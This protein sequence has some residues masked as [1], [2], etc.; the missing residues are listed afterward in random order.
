MLHCFCDED[1]CAVDLILVSVAAKG[2]MDGRFGSFFVDACGNEMARKMRGVLAADGGE[3][4]FAMESIKKGL[5]M[6]AG[7]SDDRDI[8]EPI[9]G[10]EDACIWNSGCDLRF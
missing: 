7:K 8:R 3:E 4:L 10:E 9:F 5:L 2:K 1:G 6:D